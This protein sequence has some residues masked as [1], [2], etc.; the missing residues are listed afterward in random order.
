MAEKAETG[1]KEGDVIE[2]FKL[3]VACAHLGSFEEALEWFERVSEHPRRREKSSTYETELELRLS[4]NPDDHLLLGQ[5]AFLYYTDGDYAEALEII[6]RMEKQDPENYW[7]KN[8]R[9]LLKVEMEEF[10]K[11]RDLFREVLDKEEN[12]YTRA[13]MGYAYWQEGKY[14]RAATHFIR[15]GTLLFTIEDILGD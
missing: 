10:E 6:E 8:Y 4:L 3:G 9:A 5:K 7:I 11:A 13:F 1:A 15:T 12:R 14:G 2:K